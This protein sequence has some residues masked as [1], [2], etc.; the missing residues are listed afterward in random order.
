[1][2]TTPPTEQD[3]D[4]KEEQRADELEAIEDEMRDA[5]DILDAGLEQDVCDALNGEV[6]KHKDDDD[7][8]V[9]ELT[10][11]E[12]EKNLFEEWL[13]RC[14][15]TKQHVYVTNI[16]TGECTCPDQATVGYVCKHL[17]RGLH[18]AGKTMLDLP[19][20]VT[21]KPHLT[22][23]ME[24]CKTTFV[25]VPFE[26]QEDCGMYGWG[27]VSMTHPD[28]VKVS[29]GHTPAL[30][31]AHAQHSHLHDSS[32]TPP[33]NTDSIPK[34]P[35]TASERAAAEESLRS[36]KALSLSRWLQNLKMQTSWAHSEMPDEVFFQCEKI[37]EKCTSEIR[38]VLKAATVPGEFTVFGKAK[39]SNSRTPHSTTKNK[40]LQGTKRNA[41]EPDF[42]QGKEK[43]R[44]KNK[45]KKTLVPWDKLK[46]LGVPSTLRG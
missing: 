46:K 27:S 8:A 45:N 43:G 20:S 34:L 23:D 35:T 3:E 42:V 28:V 15:D 30:D 7:G 44:K 24:V 29:F 16:S 14:R 12:G 38:D 6:S 11:E 32:N 22:N 19:S 2:D 41:G 21:G 26:Q 40:T 17:F 33:S 31:T 10:M 9:E 37:V 4:A 36:A 39:G 13:K 25:D 1:M 5:E 18:L